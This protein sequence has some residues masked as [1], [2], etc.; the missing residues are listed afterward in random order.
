M[1]RVNK[2]GFQRTSAK[3]HSRVQGFR[4]GDIITAVVPTGKKKG[5]YSG[6]VAVR[7][8]GYFN[9]TS[10]KVTIQGINHKHCQIIHGQDGYHY[11]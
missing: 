5:I 4:T 7:A 8:S 9:I 10:N 6:R 11:N 3:Q 2:Y 1:C